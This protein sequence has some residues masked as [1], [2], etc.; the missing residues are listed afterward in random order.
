MA[1]DVLT[2]KLR[3][4]TL[5]NIILLDRV[6]KSINDGN[7]TQN[8]LMCGSPGCGKTSLMKILT[9]G[10]DFLYINASDERG[11]GVIREKIDEYCATVSLMG[12]NETKY[13]L[14]DEFDGA[15]GGFFDA[16]RAKSEEYPSV[17]FI[18]TCNYINKIP[19]ALKSR[20]LVLDFM[21]K[22]ESEE[23]E[24][25]TK[26]IKRIGLL[27]SK[28]N[29]N[30]SSDDTKLHFVER[31]FPD[32]RKMVSTLQ[33][34]VDSGIES[35]TDE[36][37]KSF[38]YSFDDLYNLAICIRPEDIGKMSLTEYA[39]KKVYSEYQ[40]RLDEVM[41]AFSQ[42][43]PLWLLENY[44]DYEKFLPFIIM[45]V[46]DYQYKKTFIIDPPIA[47]LAMLFEIQ[48]IITKG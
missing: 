1:Y 38:A 3:P 33:D 12:L 37:I 7:I 29:L 22:N 11:I 18:A 4:K 34:F 13:V 14:L 25:K 8:V 40:S 47:L 16:Y 21:P 10:K 30:W 20:F 27:S 39:Y 17:R 45:K 15:T 46:T 23:V 2:E 35:I 32:F 6:R 43:F 48:T 44:P 24:L 36:D 26:Y 9:M 31:N 42:E 28:L 19:S 41:S 5:K